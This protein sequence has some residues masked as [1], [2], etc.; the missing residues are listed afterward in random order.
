MVLVS[1]SVSFSYL[2]DRAIIRQDQPPACFYILL[3]GTAIVTYRRYTD[4]HVQTVDIL[5]R[6]CTFGVR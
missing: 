1:L 5:D 3:S 6:G 2:E 4:A